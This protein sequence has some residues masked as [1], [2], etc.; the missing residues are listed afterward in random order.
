MADDKKWRATLLLPKT[1]FP[2]K[3]GLPQLEERLLAKWEQDKTYQK[4][5]RASAAR[6]KFILHDGPPY[7]NGDLHMGTAMN[8]ILKDVINRSQQ[9]LGKNAFYVPGWDCHG[10][11]IE[12]KVEENL[13][14][15]GKTR[16]SVGRA[17]L[18]AACRDFAQK[19]VT[20]QAKQFQ[21][22]G[23]WGEW[24]DPYLT[25]N[26]ES[27]AI[28]AAE[29]MKFAKSGA[30]YRALKPVM[31]SVAEKTA[32]AEAEIEYHEHISTTLFVRFALRDDDASIIIWTTTPWTLPANRAIA[33]AEHLSYGLYQ[34]PQG[35]KI[36]LADSLA[37]NAKKAAE[38]A[39]LERIKDFNPKGLV[40]DHPL[41]PLGYDFDVPL[42][43]G[44]FVTDETGTGFVHIAP[45]HGRDD[46]DLATKHNIKTP[47]M[48][49]DDGCYTEEAPHFQGLAILNPDGSQGVANAKVIE[50]L[51][52]H[53]AVFAH[54][55]LRHDYPHSWRSKT[56]IIFRATPQWFISMTHRDLRKKALAAIDE[57]EWFPKSGS[58]RLYAMVEHRPDWV[59]SRQR[60]WG[61]PLTI[62]V[63]SKG[64]VLHDDKVNQNIIEAIKTH[65]SDIWF[66]AP[67][68]TFLTEQ[69]PDD[70]H[71][72]EDIVDVWFE[73]GASHAFVLEARAELAF[74]ASLYL[75]GTDQHRG[76]FQSSLLEA[77]ATRGRAPYEKVL[78]HGF[79][80]DGKG[81]K[82]SKSGGN[83]VS[84]N[85]FVKNRGGDILRLWVASCDYEQDLRFG[86]EAW[87]QQAMLIVNC[88][89][90]CVLCSAIYTSCA[91][92]KK[93]LL[94]KC[95][96]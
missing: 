40:C 72:V 29:F 81:R 7:A 10:L 31:W 73:S 56:P 60:A 63:N 67:K 83:A 37:E 65:G 8:K 89:M 92:K 38:L 46:Y 35:E 21:R 30:L 5:R 76:W 88:A 71:K 34:T 85:D 33:F 51:N 53:K 90:L 16:E 24:H 62:F 15:K 6:E 59:I 17:G 61:V 2:M 19:W 43:S 75:E 95:P 70:W 39:T 87:Q 91:L 36:V 3:A 82:M 64:E 47:F 20:R 4:Q 41:K 94:P 74:P 23:V 55:K 44:D 18:R 9:L 78:T 45:S 58:N 93:F 80:L 54:G 77:C 14:A 42:L 28:I 49:D 1:S 66:S 86:D 25:M 13:R 52:E 12:W 50:K 84:P 27:E 22:L 68:E 26:K 96:N 48:V 11:P 57:V 79:L 69:S 32:L